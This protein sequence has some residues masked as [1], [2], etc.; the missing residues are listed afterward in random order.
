M[1]AIHIADE[2]LINPTNPIS[3]NLI[4][5]G[6]TGS[7]MLMA[8]GKIHASLLA[9][10]HP[11]LHVHLYDDDLVTELNKGRQLFADAEVG[12]HKSVALI[13]RVNRFWG[14]NWKAVTRKFRSAEVAELP[15]GG[16]ACIFVTCVDNVPAR[17]DVAE[18]LRRMSVKNRHDR[19]RPLY[20]LD[21]GNTQMTGQAL[22][23]TVTPI[24]QPPL[25]A[26]RTVAYMPMVTEEFGHM[27]READT[28]DDTPSC[29]AAEALEKQDLFI[30][31]SVA[32]EAADILWKL[33]KDHNLF[34]KGFFKN[35]E[36]YRTE[37][38][39]VG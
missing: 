29:S 2:S 39:K 23:G 28:G 3:L 8:L 20:W 27:L 35:L 15:G 22:L 34:Y 16:R 5:A 30:N 11:G 26:Y 12:L 38:I 24:E 32:N 31:P 17:F 19:D 1:K 18:V 37:G 33:L 25:E 14:T 7:H 21:C 6:G 13:N 10:G 36:T 4:G 9:L